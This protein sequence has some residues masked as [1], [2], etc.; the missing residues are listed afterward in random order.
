MLDWYTL[1]DTLRLEGQNRAQRHLKEARWRERLPR[2]TPGGVRGWRR[3]LAAL[4][5]ALADRLDP[6]TVA[7]T[8]HVPARPRLNGTPHRA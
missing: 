2:R 7:S 5:L 8:A 1:E 6:R 4:L 3:Q